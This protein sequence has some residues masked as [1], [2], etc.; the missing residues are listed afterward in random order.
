MVVYLQYMTKEFFL[1][2][3]K[4]LHGD[5]YDYSL[6]PEEL[7]STTVITIVCH[8]KDKMGYEHGPFTTTVSKHINRGDGCTK[9]SGKYK[10]TRE[11]F[12][13]EANFVHNNFYNYDKFD[14]I[15]VNT[16]GI[17]H[18]P[19]HDIEFL[20]SPIKHLSGQGC[21]KCRY[22]KSSLHKT[23]TTEE[24]I[25]RAKEIHGDKYDYS[26]VEYVSSSTKVC[27]ICPEHGEFWQT[28]ENHLHKT[29]P[30]G[31][32]TC[33]KLKCRETQK[34]T[35]ESFIEKARKVYGDKYDYSKVIYVNSVTDVEIICPK[36]GSFWQ[37]PANHLIGEQCPKCSSFRSK[38]EVGLLEY[39][40]S[41][42]S[43]EIIENDRKILEGD[44]L[45]IVL[46]DRKIC[47]EYNGLHWHSET[48]KD[49][50]YHLLKTERCQK[51]GYRLIHIFED[52][53]LYKQEIVKSR[54]NS[55]LG[56][57]DT[58][59]YARK[60]KIK[61]VNAKECSLFLDKNHIQG[62]C[63]ST[64]RIGLYYK[65]ELVSVMTFGKTRHFIGNSSHEWE[66]LRFCNKRNTLVI[67][68]ASRLYRYFENM[69]KPISVVSY[70]DRRWSV[71][72]VYDKL[73]FNLY[74]ISPP[75][76]FYIINGERKNRFNFRKS[77]LVK[78]GYDPNKSEHEI[79]LDR[80]IYRIYDCGCL[81]YEK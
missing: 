44:E 36:H 4:T 67:G 49:K 79:M 80:K 81:C 46:S 13:R 20:M 72:N 31:C 25:K 62:R 51:K 15:N 37:R 66:L 61:E 14:F 70:A 39:I 77:E 58:K 73:G 69:Y 27:I 29:K 5:K 33:G 53:W 7:K 43:G 75:N 34:D 28:P 32:P 2:K 56:I 71:G 23:K 41:V 12:I 74:N 6:V 48:T 63:G 68:G 65:N 10:R 21:P 57:Y 26:K 40:K 17:I 59:L 52:E 76:Y 60:C 8:K 78:Q 24:F 19:K 47:F 64:V 16:K 35:K 30:Q 45:D 3:A 18:C 1:E 50:N 11:D 9:C 54:I 38:G 55:I 22:E 42:Y